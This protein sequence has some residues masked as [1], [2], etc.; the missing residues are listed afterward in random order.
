MLVMEPFKK[1]KVLGW[2]QNPSSALG[3]QLGPATPEH[4]IRDVMS[5]KER[6]KDECG[7]G[8]LGQHRTRQGDSEELLSEQKECAGASYSRKME[9]AASVAAGETCGVMQVQSDTSSASASVEPPGDVDP[10]GQFVHASLPAG[11]HAH[12]F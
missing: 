5:S 9:I 4:D 11:I 7:G 3:P 1:R 10:A 2:S 12:L 8:Q 6:S